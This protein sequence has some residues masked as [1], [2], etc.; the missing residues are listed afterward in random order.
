MLHI[1]SQSYFRQILQ[2]LFRENQ[3]WAFS[4][5][6]K[7]R[8]FCMYTARIIPQFTC[9]D[10]VKQTH[11]NMVF[12]TTSVLLSTNNM[13]MTLF[14]NHFVGIKSPQRGYRQ[15]RTIIYAKYDERRV[16]LPKASH[17]GTCAVCSIVS[18]DSG[19]TS[20]YTGSRLVHIW[21]SRRPESRDGTRGMTYADTRPGSA[22]YA[23]SCLWKKANRTIHPKTFLLAIWDRWLIG[24]W[25][26][27]MLS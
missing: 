5:D 9:T 10:V 14:R 4:S 22:V 8:R 2:L 12:C 13:S 20:S 7:N 27:C 21:R 25:T 16:N 18:S 23:R 24:V 1:I 17:K 26:M 19:H 11:V 6:K 15:N 3:Y